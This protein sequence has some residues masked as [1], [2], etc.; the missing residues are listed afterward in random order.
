MWNISGKNHFN[1]LWLCVM[2]SCWWSTQSL[3]VNSRMLETGKPS[4]ASSKSVP[5]KVPVSWDGVS[6]DLLPDTG[7]VSWI[8]KYEVIASKQVP[9]AAPAPK[10]DSEAAL[11]TWAVKAQ[12]TYRLDLK[13]WLLR[14]Q[15]VMICIL[16][17]SF[18]VES[19]LKDHVSWIKLE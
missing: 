13:L 7:A 14:C 11:F 5:R 18:P 8:W 15:I 2:P 9:A 17:S 19:C 4:R 16:L 1:H 10:G 6:P 12:A 3:K